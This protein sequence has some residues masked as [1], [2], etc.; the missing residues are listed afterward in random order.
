MKYWAA[1]QAGA[2]AS[3]SPESAE[4]MDALASSGTGCHEDITEL[5]RFLRIL[6]EEN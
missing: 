1:A 4:R 2:S 3:S 6:S 5:S